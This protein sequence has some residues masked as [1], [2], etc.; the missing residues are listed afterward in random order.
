M[1]PNPRP[2]R[3]E[4]A[5]VLVAIA[6]AS[7]GAVFWLRNDAS[8]ATCCPPTIRPLGAVIP[9]DAGVRT[10][11]L[12]NGLR[13]FVRANK[14]PKQ[15]AELRLVVNAGAVL[16][17]DDQ[18]GLAHA[19]EHMAFRGT[20][21]FPRRAVVDYL[22]SIGMRE[23]EDINAST[24][25]DETVYRFT[26]P[27]NRPGVLDT[28]MAILA[29]M[30]HEVTF[31]AEQARTEG[32]IVFSEWRSSRGARDRLG[33]ERDAL[34]LGGSRYGQRPTIGD[35]AV[36]RRF[37]VHAMRRFYDDWY[38]PELMAVVAVGDFDAP[39]VEQL[40]RK[41][42]AVLPSSATPRARPK[43]DVPVVTPSRGA[44]LT[45]A[46]ATSTRV[47]LWFPR[48]AAPRRRMA[49]Y[50]REL[51]EELWRD[52]LNARLED[53]ADQ[54]GSPLLSAGI[55][56]RQLVR[57]LDA[58]VVGAAVTEGSAA[59]AV[60]LLAAEV[61]RLSIHG[62]TA[63]EFKERSEA[64]LRQRRQAQG[65]LDA[66]DD[67]AESFV[68]EFLTGSVA[69]NR[70]SAFVLARDLLPTIRIGDVRAA[71]RRV[72]IDSGALL[73]VTGPSR[74][75]LASVAPASLVARARM[76]TSRAADLRVEAPDSVTLIAHPPEPGTIESERTLAEEEAYDW[77]L[78]NGV[79]VIL[80]PTRFAA[81][82][83]EFR[84][85]GSGGA[86]LA[87]DAEY[88]S[89][90]LSDAIIGSIGVGPI[91]GARLGRM[92]DAS[93]IDLSQRVSD[94]AIEL[95]GSTGA[96]D[97]E[98]LF[99]L[100][101]L[102]FTSPRADTSAFR[103][104]RERMMAFSS[105][106]TADP[107]AVFYDTVAVTTAQHHPRALKSG[108]PF[109][110]AVSLPK[111]LAFW[112]ARMSNA[113][114][115]TLVVT[116]DFTLDRMRP[117]VLRYVGSLPGGTHERPRDNGM[118]FPTGVVRRAIVAGVGPKAKT[119]IVLS[120]PFSNSDASSVALDEARDVAELA[121]GDRLRE[122]L[123]GTY[124]VNVYSSISL[125]PPARYTLTMEFE[126]SPENIDQ[127]ADAALAE[128]AR[129]RTTGPTKAELDKTRA[130][131]VR[132]FDDKM[133]SNDY[134]ASELS[135]HARM[136]WPLSSIRSHQKVAQ[137]LTMDGL[138]DA[139]TKYL[140]AASYTRVTM[141][142][143]RAARR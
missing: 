134:W 105:R 20:R 23:G 31:D 63:R 81:D 51:I 132:D 37:D 103:R 64:L 15:R 38:R 117:L 12:A 28:A 57:P 50:R 130:A 76:A 5:A 133:E 138:R 4:T 54:P 21:H 118:R 78:S 129:L 43:I 58:E 67:V 59:E 71:A 68:D 10:G 125:V 55:D 62:P 48:A 135:W 94:E 101:H 45:D 1:P 47:S 32:G 13:Y 27:T 49:D 114:S 52:I 126:A 140:G 97:L 141:Y 29:D 100:L 137:H 33:R 56:A 22:Q 42:F 84:L 36:L 89:A 124:G 7:M 26:V 142:P 128:L 143:K 120:G 98:K 60:D 24:N 6:L 25:Q 102:Y 19:V 35:T 11:Q 17:D 106:R 86:S 66:S 44:T 74:R 80:K 16:E 91:N 90:Y 70:E 77:T 61:A 95:S 9:A 79:R 139:C 40:V 83:I 18:R 85:V 82:Q 73:L 8:P 113:S 108:A 111:A 92:L 119:Q 88:P 104:Y 34:L 109:Y 87:S 127:L 3:E 136:G 53:V 14:A 122:R 75:A 93:S 110:E 121:L 69:L 46:E 41:Q 72:S 99:Q 107:D 2:G 131:E 39:T 116:G 30:A 115:F 65:F 96:E 112:N 123:G